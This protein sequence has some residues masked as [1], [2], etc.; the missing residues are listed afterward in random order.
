MRPLTIWIQVFLSPENFCDQ[1]SLNFLELCLWFFPSISTCVSVQVNHPPL[2]TDR[3]LIADIV[4]ETNSSSSSAFM[5][6]YPHEIEETFWST[7]KFRL[8]YT[9]YISNRKK[10]ID[11]VSRLHTEVCLCFTNPW[12]QLTHIII[13]IK[14]TRK[15]YCRPSNQFNQ[16]HSKP[17]IKKSMEKESSLDS[18]CNVA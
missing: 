13:M 17:Q 15:V 6:G 11:V 18:W 16:V 12:Y 9:I 8:L 4:P 5:P 1:V 7:H 10:I 2:R 14:S 3:R